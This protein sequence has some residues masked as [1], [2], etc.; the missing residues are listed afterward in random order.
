MNGA[1]EKSFQIEKIRRKAAETAL[2]ELDKALERVQQQD[3]GIDK[4]RSAL[5]QK[6]QGIYGLLADISTYLDMIQTNAAQLSDNGQADPKIA[7]PLT[8]AKEK[9]ETLSK[10]I[11]GARRLANSLISLHFDPSRLSES[12]KRLRRTGTNT[13]RL[14][15]DELS[16]AWGSFAELQKIW[17]EGLDLISGLCLRQVGLDDGLCQI[18]D[19]IISEIQWTGV[20]AVT[21]P[22]RGGPGLLAQIVHLRFPEW[23]IWAL[24]LTAHE[25]WHLGMQGMDGEIVSG[26]SQEILDSLLENA[27]EKDT[28]A[29]Q[30]LRDS[31]QILWGDPE[32]QLCLA[33]VFGTFAMGPAYP[34]ACIWLMLD[35]SNASSEQ[36]ALA[37]FKTLEL[38]PEYGPIKAE[39]EKQWREISPT[40]GVLK[41]GDWVEAEIGYLKRTASEFK[42]ERWK[43]LRSLLV[44]ALRNDALGTLT[45]EQIKR[46]QIRY[47]LNAAW[48]GRLELRR[49]TELLK[50]INSTTRQLV[51]ILL[52]QAAESSQSPQLLPGM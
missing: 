8:I 21:L 47:V 27:E 7:I 29:G 4:L 3:S 28:V 36:R 22:G 45:K 13:L 15:P 16:H 20:K 46:L 11:D 31:A 23:T 14:R 26:S 2:S 17:D 50:T 35:P 37:M 51:T 34:C 40:S 6:R 43:E 10:S 52:E 38:I 12:T 30:R 39:L 25:L 48:K 33:D 42:V 5:A 32:L 19:V 9:L 44:D 24:P 18:A 41:Y 1:N 49:D